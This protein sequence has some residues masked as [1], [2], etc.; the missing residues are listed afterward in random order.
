MRCVFLL[1]AEIL[2]RTLLAAYGLQAA[3]QK[4]LVLA[5]RLTNFTARPPRHFLFFLEALFNFGH[6]YIAFL[7]VNQGSTIVQIQGSL[8]FTSLSMLQVKC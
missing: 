8:Q 3:S 2:I 5:T 6:F 1:T 7:L 4:P